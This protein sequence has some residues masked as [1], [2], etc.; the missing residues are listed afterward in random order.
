MREA[1]GQLSFLVV[2]DVRLS[3]TAKLAHIVFPATHFGEKDGTYTNRKGRVQKL[4]AALIAPER[5]L[6]V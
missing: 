4:N 5:L 6:R 3:E 1:L 2:Q